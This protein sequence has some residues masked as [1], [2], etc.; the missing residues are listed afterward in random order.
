M[1]RKAVRRSRNG[2]L[3]EALAS[4]IS[5]QALFLGQLARAEERFADQMGRY[6]ERFARYEERFTRIESELAAIK[7]ILLRH[8][9][10][11]E[12]LPETIRQKIGFAG[13]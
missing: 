12:A 3:E 13:D 11:L 9:Q 1:P 6:E 7:S 10:M 4:L 5:N 2:Q 8:E